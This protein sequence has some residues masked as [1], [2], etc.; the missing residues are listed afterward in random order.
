MTVHPG[1][2][3][4]DEGRETLLSAGATHALVTSDAVASL[5][6]RGIRPRG[7]WVAS[8]M[9][10]VTGWLVAL[11]V[12]LHTANGA[13]PQP[14]AALADTARP[15]AR[16]LVV[17]DPSAVQ[18]FTARADAVRRMIERG[19]TNWTGKSSTA[20]AWR[21]LL[22][23]Q[24]VVGIKVVSAPG[25]LSGTRPAVVEAVVSTMI[26]AGIGRD[27]IV[28]WDKHYSHLRTSG[29]VDLADRCGVRVAGSADVGYDT[30]HFYDSIVVGQLVWGDYEFGLQRPGIGRKSYVS[31]LITREL[32]KLISIAPLLNH[33]QAGV[34]GHLLSLA[35]GSVD[36]SIRFLNAP[37]QLQMAIP[38]ICALPEIG[39]RVVLNITDA[40]VAQYYGE[41]QT[42]LH[43]ARPLCQLRFSSDPV[44]LDVLSV[45]EIERQRTLADTPSPKTDLQLYANASLVELGVSDM[46]D[47]QVEVLR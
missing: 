3:N 6:S 26:E 28:I 12:L 20:E 44:A 18:A 32:T 31:T 10:A 34:S 29:F 33:N 4:S 8:L 41:E 17:E 22:S 46:R 11:W 25:P 39:D 27:N 38:D 43:Y 40:L 14:A 13:S 42:L 35:L 23:T 36:N 9:A 47:I 19:L 37:G 7:K 30:N 16:V 5:F 24:D 15:K 21:S 2:D 45:H 1:L